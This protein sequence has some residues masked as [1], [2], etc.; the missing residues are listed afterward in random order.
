[1]AAVTAVV[2]EQPKDEPAESATAL[3]DSASTEPDVAPS[4]EQSA[5]DQAPQPEAS[6]EAPDQATEEHRPRLRRGKKKDD[7]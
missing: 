3:A 5:S 6:L 7:A 2:D 4:P 1:V